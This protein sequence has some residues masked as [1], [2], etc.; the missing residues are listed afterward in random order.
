M[1]NTITQTITEYT[2]VPT[3]VTRMVLRPQILNMRSEFR[4]VINNRVIENNS[5]LPSTPSVESIS[6]IDRETI[7]ELN[8]STSSERR[9]SFMESVINHQNSS[10]LIIKKLKIEKS[11]YPIIVDLD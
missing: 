4:N 9:L 3:N 1:V 10:E 5:R 11:M 7:I 2:T 8:N 6:V